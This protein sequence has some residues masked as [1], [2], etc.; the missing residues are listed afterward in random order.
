MILASLLLAAALTGDPSPVRNP[1]LMSQLSGSE[2]RAAVDAA[3]AQQTAVTQS[4]ISLFSLIVQTV[5]GLG[6]AYIALKQVTLSRNQKAM[7]AG[8]QHIVDQVEQVE[9]HT[10]SMKDQLVKVTGEAE[11]A[12]GVLQATDAKSVEASALAKMVVDMVM[13]KLAHEKP[14]TRRKR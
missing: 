1:E 5:G 8:Q 10:N 4:W 9:K 11:F 13:E 12:K 3:I 2:Q 6:L 14:R 7:T